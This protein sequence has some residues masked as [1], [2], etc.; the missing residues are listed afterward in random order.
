MI[1]KHRTIIVPAD[2]VEVCQRLSV[3]LSGEAGSGMWTTPL[4]PTG[5]EPATHY[6]SSGMIGKEFIDMLVN[7]E[8]LFA[9]CQA[10]G[11]ST[12]LERCEYLI[13]TTDATDEGPFEAMKRLGLKMLITKENL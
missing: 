9:A 5:D 12:T 2:I 10:E 8:D 3:R 11:L 6:I 13:A 1:Y 7:A 4:S